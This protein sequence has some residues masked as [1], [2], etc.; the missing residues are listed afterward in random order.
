MSGDADGGRTVS[1]AVSKAQCPTRF[2]AVD[3]QLPSFPHIHWW[4]VLSSRGKTWFHVQKKLPR[5]KDS[6]Q[7]EVAQMREREKRQDGNE[8]EG[9]I[10]G[11]RKKEKER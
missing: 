8:M 6:L 5:G 7:K 2:M 4:L 3:Q 1:Q 9:L 11:K 10:G